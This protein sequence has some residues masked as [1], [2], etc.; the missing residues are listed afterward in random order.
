MD[1]KLPSVVDL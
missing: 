1:G